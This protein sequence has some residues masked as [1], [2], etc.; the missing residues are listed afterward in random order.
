MNFRN[1]VIFVSFFILSVRSSDLKQKWN[2]PFQSADTGTNNQNT[3]MRYNLLPTGVRKTKNL[4]WNSYRIIYINY[5][6][7]ANK[8]IP[9]E[10]SQQDSWF[11]DNF[12]TYA[13]EINLSSKSVVVISNNC[14]VEV[15]GLQACWWLVVTIKKMLVTLMLVT[16]L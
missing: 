12:E 4:S 5:K 7:S 2:N 11:Y 1:F 8:T 10:I 9:M 3:G 15:G 16:D 13:C 14:P 6:K